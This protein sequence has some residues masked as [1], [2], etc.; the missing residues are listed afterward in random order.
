MASRC[1]FSVRLA[2]RADALL[3]RQQLQGG[4]ATATRDDFVVLAIA[5]KD[6]GEVLQQ[7]DAR[8]A[9]GQFGDGCAHG[10]AHV[11]PGRAK[12]R[13]RNEDEVLRRDGDF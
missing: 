9:G 6:D 3:F 10:L 5:G 4:E 7:A 2:V 8:D 12:L 11:A 1:T 13:Q